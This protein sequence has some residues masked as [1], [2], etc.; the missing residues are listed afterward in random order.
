MQAGAWE[1]KEYGLRGHEANGLAEG[2][3]PKTQCTETGTSIEVSKGSAGQ[4]MPWA[5]PFFIF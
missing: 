2:P 1:T 5:S 4:S 3:S